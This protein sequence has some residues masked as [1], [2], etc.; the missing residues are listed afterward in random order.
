MMRHIGPRGFRMRVLLTLASAGFFPGVIVAQRPVTR[1]ALP[2]LIRAELGRAY[3]G[4]RFATVAPE[5][6]AQLARGQTPDWI[7]GDFDGDGRRDYA[8]QIVHPS[9][10]H[11]TQ[12]VVAFLRRGGGY[13][14]LLVSSFPQSRGAYLALAR[15]GERVADLEADLNGDSTFVLRADAVHILVGQEAGST[16]VYERGRFRCV[17]SSD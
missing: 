7:A 14:R 13:Q 1:P 6:R 9:T 5:L 4:W 16:C 11:G 15:R 3:P 12:H 17:L 10:A 8:A 2:G